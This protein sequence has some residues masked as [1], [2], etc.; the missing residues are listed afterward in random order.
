MAYSRTRTRRRYV[1]RRPTRRIPRRTIR[2]TRPTFRR[3][4]M[5]KRRILN[6][7][8]RKKQ[9]NMMSYRTAYDGTGGAIGGAT[10]L[11]S[12]RGLIFFSPSYRDKQSSDPTSKAT[13]ETDTIYARGF[14]ENITIV[15]NS[16]A[17]WRWR[18]IV[19]AM[20]GMYP[21]FGAGVVGLETS[22]GYVRLVPDYSSSAAV[23]A[24]FNIEAIIF[25]GSSVVDWI[26]PLTAKVDT[27]RVTVLSDQIRTLSSGNAQ[28]RFF[29]HRRWY[30]INKNIVYAA[31]EQ[32]EVENSTAVST[33]AKPGIGDIYVIDYFECATQNAADTLFFEPECTFYW[34]EK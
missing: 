12:T 6:I 30:P 25:R 32:G 29:K 11:G 13:R 22:N 34:H 1:R 31:D 8:S 5:S 14:K 21:A 9:D 15:T 23:T 4:M 16:A 10:L 24:R 19:F 33:L 20:K 17:S 3:R 27:S 18:R 2:P 28:G 26:T 7:T